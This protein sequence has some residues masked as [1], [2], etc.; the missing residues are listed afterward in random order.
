MIG[1]NTKKEEEKIRRIE[2][3]NTSAIWH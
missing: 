1:R 2:I 3:N